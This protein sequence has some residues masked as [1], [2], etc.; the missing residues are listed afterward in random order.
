M[1]PVSLLIEVE[2][3][4]SVPSADILFLILYGVGLFE[5]QDTEYHLVEQTIIVVQG[6]SCKFGG[7]SDNCALFVL[8]NGKDPKQSARG[9]ISYSWGVLLH[10]D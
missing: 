4:G 2:T 1:F 5:T 9:D 7:C 3:T 6:D 10:Y 8:S